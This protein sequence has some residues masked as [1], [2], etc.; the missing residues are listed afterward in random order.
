MIIVEAGCQNF[1]SE[2]AVNL[3]QSDAQK[4][5]RSQYKFV[6]KLYK[7]EVVSQFILSYSVMRASSPR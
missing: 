6:R 3:E 5:Q 1:E 4:H 7:N 2:N